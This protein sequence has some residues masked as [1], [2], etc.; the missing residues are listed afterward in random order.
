MAEQGMPDLPQPLDYQQTVIKS[1][2]IG[3]VG[4]HSGEYAVVRVR[5]AFAGEGRYFVRV[6]EGG[7]PL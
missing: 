2:T 5:P 3:G 7:V 6:P 1:F 4:L